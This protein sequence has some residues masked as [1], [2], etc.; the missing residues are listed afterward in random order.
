[1][2]SNDRQLIS[3]WAESL[4]GRVVDAGCGP[5]HWTQLLYESGVDVVGIDMVEEFVESAK[6]RFPS[7]PFEVG[8]FA[9]LPFE[10]MQLGGILAWYSTIH[11][12]PTEMPAVLDE[13]VRCLQPG[14]SLLMGFFSGEDIEKFNHAIAPAYFW[15]PDELRDELSQRGLSVVRVQTR[16]D[17]GSRPHG[18]LWA[19]KTPR[20]ELPVSNQPSDQRSEGMVLSEEL[21]T[22]AEAEG[23]EKF[24]VGAVIHD[25]GRVLVV[26]RSLSDD[27]L[28]GLEEVPSGGVDSGEGLSEAL[29]RE[30]TE[31]V[32]FAAEHVDP[33][34]L[35]WF[36]YES[37]SGRRTR[38]FTVSVPLTGRQVKLSEEHTS[39]R[40]IS[41]EQVDSTNATP[42]TK[43]L[44]RS[45]FTAAL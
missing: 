1:M 33:G 12:P 31:E 13:F 27:F 39:Y 3:E 10:D 22:A 37:R 41:S 42:E 16:H 26:T 43:N 32:G 44:L 15:P 2:A 8:D 34:F 30:L 24:V 9:S 14:G 19:R 20:E 4:T 45:W 28:P 40:W 5:G 21:R 6:E 29:N 18:A 36:D 38:Q 23:I 35:E 17:L 25:V 11:I 7:T